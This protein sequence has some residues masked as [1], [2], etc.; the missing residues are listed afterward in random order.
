[1]KE[2]QGT[3]ERRTVPRQTLALPVRIEMMS[4]SGGSPTV[5]EG[6]TRD[7][8]CKGAYFWGRAVFEVGQRLR[9]AWSIPPELNRQLGLEIRCVAE[10]VRVDPTQPDK[11]G[12]G[13]AIRVLHFET[14]QV[15]SWP[16]RSPQT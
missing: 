5:I 3:T 7:V 11:P 12:M 6:L 8:S 14:P 15:T 2:P 13:V 1:M 10:V 16:D 9:L 4:S